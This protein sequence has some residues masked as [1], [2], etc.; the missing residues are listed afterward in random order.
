MDRQ[1][2]AFYVQAWYWILG[3]YRILPTAGLQVPKRWQGYKPETGPW[4]LGLYVSAKY[5]RLMVSMPTFSPLAP[6]GR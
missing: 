2:T 6:T 1:A 5:E 3:D 4:K